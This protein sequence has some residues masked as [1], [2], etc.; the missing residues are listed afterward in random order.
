MRAVPGTAPETF[1]GRE[2]QPL[3]CVL[4]KASF[5]RDRS[6]NL[7][8][9]SFAPKAQP[10]KTEYKG[11]YLVLGEASPSYL[12]ACVIEQEEEK[13]TSMDVRFRRYFYER[14]YVF[15]EGVQRI[16]RNKSSVK[17]K[18]STHSIRMR[19]GRTSKST[20]YR[21]QEHSTTDRV[22]AP[23]TLLLLSRG[24]AADWHNDNSIPRDRWASRR[25]G[26]HL[27]LALGNDRRNNNNRVLYW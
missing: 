27:Q 17:V 15:A 9:C 6:R 16:V 25:G 11:N 10:R 19:L 22:G 2:P 21:E 26:A 4:T 23:R 8:I 3:I 13:G 7:L 12:R 14:Q 1:D 20:I 24:I 18:V 5:C